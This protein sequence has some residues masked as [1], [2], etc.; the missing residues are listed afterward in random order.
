MPLR[1][2]AGT[3]GAFAGRRALF[4]AALIGGAFSAAGW[5]GCFELVF[6]T[7]KVLMPVP[8]KQDE[9]AR[10]AGVATVPGVVFAATVVGWYTQPPIGATPSQALDAAGWANFVR[11]LPLKRTA[12]MLSR[13]P[14]TYVTGRHGSRILRVGTSATQKGGRRRAMGAWAVPVPLNSCS[15]TSRAARARGSELSFSMR[16]SSQLTHSGTAELAVAL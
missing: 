10:L 15:D 16:R 13:C 14:S 12:S 1:F 11:S 5:F 6:S 9:R 4:P 3:A 7:I 2:I 8:A